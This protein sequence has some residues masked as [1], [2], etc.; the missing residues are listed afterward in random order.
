MEYNSSKINTIPA[1]EEI[2]FVGNPF[3]SETPMGVV[4]RNYK[5][6]C[7]RYSK[8]YLGST[9]DTEEEKCCGILLAMF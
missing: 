7:W 1:L 3:S 6:S 4:S 9:R 8:Q 2:A 5:Q